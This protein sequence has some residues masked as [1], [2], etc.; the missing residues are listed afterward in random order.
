M[1]ALRTRVHTYQHDTVLRN[2]YFTER[3]KFSFFIFVTKK[4]SY[5]HLFFLCKK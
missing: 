2:I 1:S 5:P 4:K 3:I